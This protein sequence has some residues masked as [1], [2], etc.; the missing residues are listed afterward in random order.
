MRPCPATDI[1]SALAASLGRMIALQMGAY[2]DHWTEAEKRDSAMR[3]LGLGDGER[4][5]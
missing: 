4:D 5:V 1:A 3:A 2:P